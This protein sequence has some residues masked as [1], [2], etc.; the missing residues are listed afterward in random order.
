YEFGGSCGD[1][2]IEEREHC[3]GSDLDGQS[4]SSLG[5]GS[6]N[7]ACT[8]ECLFDVSDCETQPVCGD[9]VL[10]SPVE[11]CEGSNL[12]GMTCQD[13]GY[14]TGTLACSPT[15]CRFNL[16]GCSN[17][18]M[19]GNGN[20]E[21]GTEECDGENL[22]SQTCVSLG[23]RDGTLSC[24]EGCFFDVTDCEA[25]GFCGDNVLDTEFEVCDGTSLGGETCLT[26]G[27]SGG[28]LVCGENCDQF[29]T[30]ACTILGTCDGNG[31][32]TG[33]ECDGDHFG[34]ETCQ[35]LGYFGGALS[36]TIGCS[37]DTSDCFSMVKVANGEVHTCAL[38][39]HGRIWCWGSNNNGQL[40][41]TAFAVNNDPHYLPTLIDHSA[42]A[43]GE[44]FV[45]LSSGGFFS[46]ALTSAGRVFCWG[47][48]DMYAVDGSTS[49][50]FPTPI[51][52]SIPS[53]VAPREI[54]SGQYHTCLR[55]DTSDLW[56]WGN[57]SNYQ[58]GIDTG[59][60]EFSPLLVPV[61]LGSTILPGSGFA[62]ASF[63]TC[64]I[65]ATGVVQ[66]W[67]YNGFGQLGRGF[68]DEQAYLA[69][70][71]IDATALPMG[72]LFNSVAMGFHNAC[73]L[74]TLGQ[75]Y[76]WGANDNGELGIGSQGP[77]EGVTSPAA[78]VGGLIFST[79]A[80]G[81]DVSCAVESTGLVYCWGRGD[82]G[83]LGNN[84]FDTIVSTTPVATVPL[85]SQVFTQVSIAPSEVTHVC[86]LNNS[87]VPFCWGSNERGQ[88][89]NSSL[90][91]TARPTPVVAP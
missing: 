51:E 72:T 14:V 7:L 15:V 63:S 59:S 43:A 33:E 56:C 35:T 27:Y 2:L 6:G 87:G 16:S 25:H 74:T 52:I 62:G 40:G 20:V 18:L 8:Q 64:A 82:S 58:L 80:T 46:C 76:C 66:C 83:L 36:C 30:N 9:D 38:D 69:P 70:L 10:A 78:V 39:T 31:I 73:A 53:G 84:S 28:A 79:I 21:T 75:A 68:S 22:D 67:G 12:G 77:G 34:G 37:R 60:V 32:D 3:E 42:L 26:Q 71:S 65:D 88:L 1:G 48:G 86:A 41:T 91:D 81:H 85:L 55:T 13:L 47:D 5:L 49:Q 23:Y 50:L 89:G 61:P 17:S 57:N 45:D 90:T 54:V 4:C 11:D 19:C 29:D 24:T 44:L